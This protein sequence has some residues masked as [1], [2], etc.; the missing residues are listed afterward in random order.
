MADPEKKTPR[1]VPAEELANEVASLLD[2]ARERG[3]QAREAQPPSRKRRVFTSSP[4]KADIADVLGED[5]RQILES[6]VVTAVAEGDASGMFEHE[7]EREIQKKALVGLRIQTLRRLADSMGLD[8]RG[9]VEDLAERLARAY[10]YDEHAIAE[11]ISENLDEPE[12]DRRFSERIFPLYKVPDIEAVRERASWAVGRYIRVGVARWISFEELEQ[13]DAGM[14][15][16][17][18]ALHSYRAYVTTEDDDVSLGSSPSSTPV[19]L[20]LRSDE[21]TISIENASASVAR[22][23]LKALEAV[24]DIRSLGGIPGLGGN[25]LMGVLGTFDRQ[26]VFLLDLIYNR[27][28]RAGG[29]KLNLTAAKFRMSRE[30]QYD[31][32]DSDDDRPSLKSVRFEGRHLLDSIPAC[33]LIAQEGRALVDI[34]LTVGQAL[35]SSDEEARFPCRFTLDRDHVAVMTGFGRVPALA[36]S[37]HSALVDVAEREIDEGVLDVDRLE[38]LAQRIAQL[39]REGESPDKPTM[40]D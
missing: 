23:A 8:R 5:L 10:R 31:Q 30:D 35:G 1:V 37:L 38:E 11:L 28:P 7:V 15:S 18:G 4:K 26:T 21:S 33:E 24:S 14:L 13:D 2:L 20:A 22:A 29:R 17:Y 39:S 40:L 19:K 27:V 12:P 9:R 32:D 34:S 16:I 36:I 3:L 6:E 25:G